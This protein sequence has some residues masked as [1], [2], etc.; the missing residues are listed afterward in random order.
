[1]TIYNETKTEILN[2]NIDIDKGYLKADKILKEHHEAVAEVKGK[3]AE[4]IYNEALE[5]GEK[6][7][8]FGGE[9]CKILEE[10]TALNGKLGRTVETIKAIPDTPAVE[11]YDEY[12][13]IQVYVPYTE[14][15]LESNKKK[16]YDSLTVKYIREKYS[17]DDENKILREKLAGTAELEFDEY[18]A[19]VEECKV[20]AHKE[21]YGE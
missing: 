18:N 3:T 12:E 1:M 8:I 15:E 4:E 10:Y 2:D 19:Y 17:A 20:K 11:A 6:V 13:D 16:K 5:N 7:G 21:V 14:D 9:Y